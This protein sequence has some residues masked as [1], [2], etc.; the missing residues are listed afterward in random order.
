MLINVKSLRD[1]SLSAI[2]IN[3][4]NTEYNQSQKLSTVEMRKFTTT[5]NQQQNFN[6]CCDVHKQIEVY[7]QSLRLES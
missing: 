4:L 2:F 3:E 5:R 6:L 1:F 7:I